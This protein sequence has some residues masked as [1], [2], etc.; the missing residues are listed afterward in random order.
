MRKNDGVHTLQPTGATNGCE[1]KARV[2][3]YHYNWGVGDKAK[4]TENRSRGIYR[5]D[6]KNLSGSDD[7]NKEDEEG[8]IKG[9][10]NPSTSKAEASRRKMSLRI[11]RDD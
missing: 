5:L 2:K 1:I 8:E 6:C 3:T 7:S 4:Y 9:P 11:G 10:G